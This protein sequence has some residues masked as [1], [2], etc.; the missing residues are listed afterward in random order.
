MQKWKLCHWCS[1]IAFLNIFMFWKKLF[2]CGP[3]FLCVVTFS[4]LTIYFTKKT[5][6]SCITRLQSRLIKTVIIK[7]WALWATGTKWS[8]LV[9]Y[10]NTPF[11]LNVEESI[12][13]QYIW[14]KTQTITASCLRLR[15]YYCKNFIFIPNYLL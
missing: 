9:F 12:S 8:L 3:C 6:T 10:S 5:L 2:T 1:L 14:S 11:K 4:L 7:S 15:D 13:C